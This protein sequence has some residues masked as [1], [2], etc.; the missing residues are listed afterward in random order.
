MF[1]QTRI[2]GTYTRV[3]MD[4]RSTIA[5]PGGQTRRISHHSK[6][7]TKVAI[8]QQYVSLL[9]ASTASTGTVHSGNILTR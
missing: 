7:N 2:A 8:R 3:G 9:K 4:S 5:A 1:D 6:S